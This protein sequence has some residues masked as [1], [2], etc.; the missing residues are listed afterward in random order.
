M[1]HRSAA[2]DG[3]WKEEESGRTHPSLV[4]KSIVVL[5]FHLH[6]TEDLNCT[7]LSVKSKNSSRSYRTVFVRSL[8]EVL[9]KL[10]PV[11]SL[12]QVYQHCPL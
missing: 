12:K 4:V 9:L 11:Q 10:D 5:V 6:L 7:G 8:C 2:E 3:G 1:V